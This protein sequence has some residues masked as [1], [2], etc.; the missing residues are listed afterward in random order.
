ME[1]I[2]EDLKALNI[3]DERIHYEYF[4]TGKALA[5]TRPDSASAID[6]SDRA[7]VPVK[8]AK[9]GLEVT[10]DPAQGTLLDLVESAGLDAEYSCRSGI[11]QTC[12]V[13]LLAGSVDYADPPAVPPPEGTALICSAYPAAGANGEAAE[14]IVLDI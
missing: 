1:A 2:Y 13:G 3:A 10:W 6:L 8:F 12:A 5:A 9:S 14:P 7:P 11:C 4:G